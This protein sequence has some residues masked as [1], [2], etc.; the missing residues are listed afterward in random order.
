[1]EVFDSPTHYYPSDAMPLD[2][3][4]YWI[5]FNRVSGIG[6][7][8][9]KSLLNYFN[10]DLPAAWQAGSKELAQAGLAQKAIEN[11]TKLRATSTPQ[12]ELEKLERLRIRV[13]TWKDKAYPPLLREIDDSP[14]V[15]YTYGKLTEVDQFALAVVGTR[16][17][18]TYGRQVTERI[19]GDLVKGQVTIV[20]GLALGIDTIAHTAAL[21]G[22]GRTIAVLACG[23]DIIYPS[24]NRGLARRMVE[25]GQGV[26][27]T[28]YPLGVQPEGGNFPARNRTV[29]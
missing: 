11:L 18:T 6:P 4:A 9:F 8:S 22:G 7:V 3:L 20:S 29:R 19:V 26:L 10:G 2:E 27:V 12:Q 16:N 5:A 13:I 14:P 23:L 17:S 25:S 15:L 21:D 24:T 1:M 28:E